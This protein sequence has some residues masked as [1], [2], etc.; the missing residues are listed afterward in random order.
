MAGREV[1]DS[2]AHPPRSEAL[3]SF[4]RK[5]LLRWPEWS[6]AEVFVP[7]AQRETALAWAALL[8]ELTDAAW[9]GTDPRPGEVKLA[10]WQEELHG[11]AA[12]RRR[13]PLGAVLQRQ[14]AP[15]QPLARSLVALPASR[16]RARDPEEAFATLAEFS[17]AVAAV[18][19][20]L[21]GEGDGA[22]AS[23]DVDVVAASLLSARAA[24]PGD[25]HVPLSF[26][27][28]AQGPAAQAWRNHLLDNWP[29]SAAL[30]RAR[31]LWA[32]LA[33]TRLRQ[34]DAARPLPSWRAL[35]VA[36]R[37]ARDGRN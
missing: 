32:A 15:W 7:E 35:L 34:D 5:W 29:S 16:E 11:W 22:T 26:L 23:S 30:T 3:E 14:Q 19:S 28:D 1:S 17:A 6:V 27:A 8:Q 18:E 21:F 20:S 36:W 37:S 25:A 12:G 10:W 31:R 2:G 24:Q 13:H 4:I 9:S 33:R